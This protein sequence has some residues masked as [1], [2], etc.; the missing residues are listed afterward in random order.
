MFKKITRRSFL[1]QSAAIGIGSAISGKM[2]KSNSLP[3]E[4]VDIS[5]VKSQNYYE[6]TIKAV[7]FLGG[8]QKFIPE[9]S[10]VAILANP[11]SN[12]P[13]T[14][15]KPEIVQA[16][17]RM[18]KYAGA[19]DIGCI[20]WL[21]K[22]MWENTGI[23]KVIDSEGADLVITNTRFPGQFRKVHVPK[24]AILKEARIVRTYF[25]Y[26]ILVN[27]NITKEHSGVCFS[28]VMKNLMGMNS[29]A[30]DQ[31]FHRTDPSTGQDSIPHLEQ[32]IADLNTI[33]RPHLCIADS[34]EFVITN[35]P[36]GPGRLKTP[37]KVIAGTD[38]VAIDSFCA[39]FFGLKPENVIAIRKAYEHGL[40]EMD[41]SKLKI[42]EV[43]I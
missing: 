43:E 16:V 5:V 35:G 41:L 11:Q 28:G 6:A 12:N 2:S 25:N 42:K 21:P 31:T 30:S 39:S 23:K 4:P 3:D 37:M 15:T 14:Y 33:I 19:R 13:G 26:D 22:Y 40:G 27:I 18:C 34:T 7:E 1:K 32:C 10:R 38:R 9:N 36:M 29:P 8:M 20:G 24:G 17:I